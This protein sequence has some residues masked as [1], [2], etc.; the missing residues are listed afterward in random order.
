MYRSYS[1]DLLRS[2]EYFGTTLAFL[3]LGTSMYTDL[4]RSKEYFGTTLEFFWLQM[5]FEPSP[6]AQVGFPRK[7]DL[8]VAIEV[9]LVVTSLLY[10]LVGRINF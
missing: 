2:K 4:I 9:G 6:T 3:V 5:R 8:L 7:L 1:H 10:Y